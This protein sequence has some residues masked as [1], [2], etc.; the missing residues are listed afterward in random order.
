MNV[1]QKIRTTTMIG[2]GTPI[3]KSNRF[4]STAFM[5]VCRNLF[6]KRAHPHASPSLLRHL[7]GQSFV[8][9]FGSQSPAAPV[10]E[11]PGHWSLSNRALLGQLLH[12]TILAQFAHQERKAL[13][14]WRHL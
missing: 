7:V 5:A 13:R 1:N 4:G 2:N 11:R 3:R 8:Q 6:G 12:A 9:L 10:C 14:T